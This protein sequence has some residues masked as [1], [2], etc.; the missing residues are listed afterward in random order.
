MRAAMAFTAGSSPS[1]SIQTSTSPSYSIS[2]IATSV[3]STM[4][5][6]SLAGTMVVRTA[7][8]SPPSGSTGTG[9]LAWDAKI[10]IETV[11]TSRVSSTM[12]TAQNAMRAT[13]SFHPSTQ[14]MP[15]PGTCSGSRSQPTKARPATALT[16]TSTCRVNLVQG[17]ATARKATV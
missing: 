6:G 1:S 3:R 8:R 2:F 17:R 12:I 9:S 11:W 16:S 4:S 7:T 10:Q 5:I 13:V 14:V 15:A